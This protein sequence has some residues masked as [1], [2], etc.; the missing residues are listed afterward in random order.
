MPL[1]QD[2]FAVAQPRALS[3]ETS[4]ALS[5]RRRSAAAKITSEW[6]NGVL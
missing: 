5:S 1:V 3:S 2:V 4:A 6:K